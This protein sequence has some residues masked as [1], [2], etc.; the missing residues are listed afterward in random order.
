M[1]AEGAV[2]QNVNCSIY[3]LNEAVDR[4][5]EQVLLTGRPLRVAVPQGQLLQRTVFDR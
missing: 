4:L 5:V 3:R 1:R 2:D